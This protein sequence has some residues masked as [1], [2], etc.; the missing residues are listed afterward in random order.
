MVIGSFLLKKRIFDEQYRSD[1]FQGVFL[2]LHKSK[3]QY[4]PDRPFIKWLYTIC[5]SE[6]I[7]NLRKNKV[8][9]QEFK[10]EYMDEQ[11]EGVESTLEVPSMHGL[12]KKEKDAIE[13]KY[14]N[15]KE[16]NEISLL[17]NVSQ[18]NAR[19]LV[20]RGLSKLRAKTAGGN[21]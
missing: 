21:K 6:L 15:E 5:R 4:R 9:F 10:E 2:K 17:L 18:S 12:S 11:S 7:D 3:E 13:L 19:K 1:I 20:S 8:T 16:Y 14:I